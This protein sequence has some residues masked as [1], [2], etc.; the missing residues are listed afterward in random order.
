VAK[1]A[2]IGAGHLGSSPA[3]IGLKAWMAIAFLGVTCSFLADL[4]YFLALGKTASQK[5]GVYLYTIPPHDLCGLLAAP[6]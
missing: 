3:Q 6:Q 1:I 2:F 4:L 5:V